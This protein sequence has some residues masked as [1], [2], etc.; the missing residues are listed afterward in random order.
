MT[1]FIFKSWKLPVTSYINLLV[2]ILAFALFL[3]RYCF[4]LM[5]YKNKNYGGVLIILI[6]FSNAI[7]L[8]VIQKLRKNKQKKKLHEVYNIE[9]AAQ[10]GFCEIAF[11]G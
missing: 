7:F 5:V 8:Y 4:T 3:E 1:Y 9:V 11:V 10:T 6:I 2:L